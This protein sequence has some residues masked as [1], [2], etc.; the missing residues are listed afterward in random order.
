MNLLDYN[1]QLTLS[2]PTTQINHKKGINSMISLASMMA[3]VEQVKS[4]D[5]NVH[6]TI[7]GTERD[8]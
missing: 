1:S 3:P 5:F 8:S 6:T 4:I 2:R 7:R